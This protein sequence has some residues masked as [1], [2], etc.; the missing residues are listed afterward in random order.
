[1]D[2]IKW[3]CQWLP[4]GSDVLP[5]RTPWTYSLD[6]PLDVLPRR[7]PW[8]YSLDVLPGR[9]PLTYSID[10]LPGRTPWTYSL[11]GQT[12]AH[13]IVIR[14]VKVGASETL[15]RVKFREQ[16]LQVEVFNRDIY[17]DF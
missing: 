1:M 5:G 11:D 13:V 2:I 8:T 3:F 12:L 16:V 10:V 4:N 6:V 14:K 9:T 15:E 7:T 17:A